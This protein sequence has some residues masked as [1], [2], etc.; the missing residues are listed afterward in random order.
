MLR[1][2][3]KELGGPLLEKQLSDLC[4]EKSLWDIV[5][6]SA[7]VLFYCIKLSS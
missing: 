5:L 4:V 1:K 6:Y 3:K 7:T 2:S